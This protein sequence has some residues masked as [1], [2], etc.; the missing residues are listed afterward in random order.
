VG[1]K[2]YRQPVGKLKSSG[3]IQEKTLT[4]VSSTTQYSCGVSGQKQTDRDAKD[5]P[6]ASMRFEKNRKLPGGTW[7]RGEA[8]KVGGNANL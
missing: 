7:N 8:T 6:G 2:L 5:E 4:G 3:G 1:A